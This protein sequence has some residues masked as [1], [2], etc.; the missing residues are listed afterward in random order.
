[1]GTCTAG[2]L[3]STHQKLISKHRD[4]LY[5]TLLALPK[6]QWSTQKAVQCPL[7]SLSRAGDGKITWLYLSNARMT[8][9]KNLPAHSR[10]T[11][12]CYCT[13]RGDFLGHIIAPIIAPPL[14]LPLCTWLTRQSLVRI[15]V[16]PLPNTPQPTKQHTVYN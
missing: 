1:M 15:R 14:S 2:Q 5:C 3:S 11:I 8:A 16:T 4:L 6:F 7:M 9:R 10:V 12:H 13:G